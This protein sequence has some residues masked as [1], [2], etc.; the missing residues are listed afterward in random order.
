MSEDLDFLRPFEGLLF[1]L[2]VEVRIIATLFLEKSPDLERTLRPA[3]GWI[4]DV[5]DTT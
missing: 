3:G 5:L 2:G 4:P 1:D